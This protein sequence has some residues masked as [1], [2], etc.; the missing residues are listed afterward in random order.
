MS[1]RTLPDIA[2]GG[3]GKDHRQ[4]RKPPTN[5]RFDNAIA[6]IADVYPIKSYF[7]SNKGNGHAYIRA[8]R[9]YRKNG[10]VGQSKKERL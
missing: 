6:H 9:I 10:Q 8:R 2:H 3:I 5:R 1:T 7:N 4:G